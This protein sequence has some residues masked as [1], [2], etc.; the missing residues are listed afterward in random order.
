MIIINTCNLLV[1]LLYHKYLRKSPTQ[2]VARQHIAAIHSQCRQVVV[3]GCDEL[4]GCFLLDTVHSIC[5]HHAKDRA[6]V[7][8]VW[9]VFDRLNIKL[10]A[11]MLSFFPLYLSLSRDVNE[12]HTVDVDEKAIPP[13]M[14]CTGQKMEDSGVYILGKLMM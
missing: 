14:R 10:L 1:Q 3:A 6:V 13:L 12:Q 9:L 8:F 4:L 11:V 7:H 2:D 5:R